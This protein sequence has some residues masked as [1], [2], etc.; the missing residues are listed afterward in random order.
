MVL[1]K[2]NFLQLFNYL[3][4]LNIK[5]FSHYVIK[6]CYKITKCHISEHIKYYHSLC[7]IRIETGSY[8]PALCKLLQEQRWTCLLVKGKFGTLH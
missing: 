1:R 8:I 4:I 2:N 3:I 6:P 5:S 7:E